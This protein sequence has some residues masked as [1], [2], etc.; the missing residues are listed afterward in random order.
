MLDSDVLSRAKMS[1]VSFP[2]HLMWD[3]NQFTCRPNEYMA[4]LIKFWN[5]QGALLGLQNQEIALAELNS[6]AKEA[7]EAHRDTATISNP[8]LIVRISVMMV[9]SAS[10]SLAK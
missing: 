1:A 7:E 4:P 3:K 2:D 10:T 9:D 5:L 8:S 6:K